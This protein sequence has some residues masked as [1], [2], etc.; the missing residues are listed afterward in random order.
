MPAVSIGMPIY[1]KPQF[2]EQALDSLL[3]Q[4]FRDFELLISDNA[5]P[6]P[7]IREICERYTKQDSRIRYVRQPET[8]TAMENFSFVYE[9]TTAPYF[10]WAA[11]DD[12]WE[13]AFVERGIVALKADP[14]KSAWLPQ[15]DRIDAAGKVTETYPPV[16][17]MRSAGRKRSEI[18]RFL[19]DAQKHNKKVMLI[20]ALFRREAVHE[21]LRVLTQNQHMRGADNLFAYA[22]IC[23]NDL[24][25]DDTVLMHKRF[26]PQTRKHPKLHT[27]NILNNRHFAGY[28]RA[29]SGTPHHALTLL[30]LPLRFALYQA[31]KIFSSATLRGR[32]SRL[33]RN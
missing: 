22:Y 11:D 29:A 6:D 33:K 15:F 18:V 7:R 23:R 17:G 30:L 31:D 26:D 28:S 2:L 24:A 20:Y 12:I 8:R 19:L 32:K 25:T 21:P 14:A 4:T 10:M 3:A 16:S 9:N 5:S 13:P 1:N 27:W